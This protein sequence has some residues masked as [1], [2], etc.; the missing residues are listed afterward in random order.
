MPINGNGHRSMTRTPRT[1]KTPTAGQRTNPEKPD[2]KRPTERHAKAPPHT[3]RNR[4]SGA[5]INHE[6]CLIAQRDSAIPCP[7]TT[8]HLT[9]DP[10][11]FPPLAVP[12]RRRCRGSTY[13]VSAGFL[14]RQHASVTIIG[15]SLPAP[16]GLATSF[17][18]PC[19]SSKA[20]RYTSGHSNSLLPSR[21]RFHHWWL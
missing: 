17:F 4:R 18:P 11:I 13:F 15:M 19:P 12:S 6:Q 8:P 21:G 14:F 5:R 3:P 7:S 9:A 20:K 16:D 1:E 10:R 2:G